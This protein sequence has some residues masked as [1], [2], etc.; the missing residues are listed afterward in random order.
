MF[1]KYHKKYNFNK[2]Y[3]QKYIKLAV[4]YELFDIYNYCIEIKNDNEDE[5]EDEDQYEN[6]D[7]DED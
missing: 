4:K 6:E 1:I 7:E 3:L 2:I 5:D